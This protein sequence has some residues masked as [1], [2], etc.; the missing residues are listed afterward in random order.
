MTSQS[1]IDTDICV[2]GG[3]SGGL[4][5][6]AGAVQMG[7]RVVLIEKGAMGGD[8]L[9]VGCVPS[10]ALLAA[11]K[12]AQA[13][14]KGELFGVSSVAPSIAYDRVQSHIRE[15][16]TAIAPH[17]SVERFEGLGVTVIRASAS[18]I[19]KNEVE[20]GGKVIRAKRFVIATG[21]SPAI[22]PIPGLA[23]TPFLT[24]ET[25]WSLNE[26][27]HR[28]IVIGGGPIGLEMAQ[29][30]RRLGSDVA[31]VEI[32]APLAKDDPALAQVVVE[33]LSAEGVLFKTNVTVERVSFVENRFR[34][35]LR[36][37]SSLSAVLEGSHLI[38]ATGR[39][40]NVTGLNLEA[41]SVAFSR[42]GINVDQ[43]L[44]TSNK[45]I[46]A[47]GDVATGPGAGLQF[48]H[49][50]SYHAGIVIRNAL[51]RIPA[52][53]KTDHIPWTTYTD[54]ELAQVGLTTDQARARLGSQAEI[55]A[56]SFR[57][58]DRAQAERRTTGCI[59]V[60]LDAKGRIYG[61][62]IVGP[63]AGELIQVWALAL[64]KGLKI[65]DIAGMVAP[66]PTLG[67]ISKRAAG[68][69]FAPKLFASRTRWI[70]RQLLR[71]G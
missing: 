26:K 68:Q 38:V 6:A 25:L 54:P 5:V 44:R 12:Q 53:S 1:I 22:P 28:L 24:N 33:A 32:A 31:V 23:E 15:I 14:R 46:F 13:M 48:T 34:V 7:A 19:S 55:L 27:P 40:P 59:R 69:F 41:A 8:C 45:R 49:M 35:S 43:R 29:A 10:K 64:S 42:H 70:V 30:H 57:D 66:Y 60:S 9:N 56:W 4:S 65:K 67:E 2:I 71:L 36:N 47:I 17:D 58:N 62:G 20:A 39:S 21:S 51:F 52:K 63:N 50:A 37:G 18:F 16:I 3:G 11:A 61:A